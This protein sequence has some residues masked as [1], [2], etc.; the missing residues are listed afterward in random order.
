MDG[1][2]VFCVD[3]HPDG[4]RLASGGNDNRIVL[5]DTTSWE[6][7]H[8]LRG[9]GSYVKALVFNPDGTQLASASGDFTVKIWDTVP[10]AERR[11]QAI[12]ARQLRDG[13]RPRIES[14]LAE[15]KEPALVAEAI[16]TGESL[17]RSERAAARRV[18][19][20]ICRQE[21]AK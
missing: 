6:P 9:H 5:W 17:S 11:R 10:R 12:E 18:L 4:S 2:D 8:E 13:L 16:E 14:L 1:S 15:R 20:G 21:S 19:L 7:V 3:F